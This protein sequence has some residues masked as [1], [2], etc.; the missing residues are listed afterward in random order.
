MNRK[1]EELKN[2]LERLGYDVMWHEEHKEYFIETFEGGKHVFIWLN[3]YL[4]TPSPQQ[5]LP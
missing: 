2:L 5:D 1:A 4:P 3:D